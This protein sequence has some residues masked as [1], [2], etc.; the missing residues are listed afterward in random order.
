MKGIMNIICTSRAIAGAGRD[1]FASLRHSLAR[2]CEIRKKYV[3]LL[4]FVTP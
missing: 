2:R 1:N 4:A 3:S